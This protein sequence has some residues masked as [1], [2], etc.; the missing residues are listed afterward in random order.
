MRKKNYSLIY[1]G[2]LLVMSGISCRHEDPNVIYMPDMVYSPALKAQQPGTMIPP[3]KGTVPR[4][5][6]PYPYPRDPELAGK[7]LKNVLQP[8]LTVLK[9]GQSIYN[10]YCIVCHGPKGKGDGSIIPK[11]PRP[12]TLLSEKVKDWSDGRIYHTITMGQNLMPSYA[13]QVAPGDRWAVIHYVRALQR[14][15]NPTAEDLKIFNQESK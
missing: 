10:V 4:D 3:V 15:E 2:L 14:A 5:F 8:T 6:T 11:F 1:L 12:P 13:S 9:R 7:N